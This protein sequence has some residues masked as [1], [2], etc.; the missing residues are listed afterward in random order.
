ML[1]QCRRCALHLLTAQRTNLFSSLSLS[2]S[3]LPAE[4]DRLSSRY[5]HANPV[6][7]DIVKQEEH[8]DDLVKGHDLVVR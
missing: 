4:L 3:S 7:L 6:H 8:L 1:K 2:A 5:K